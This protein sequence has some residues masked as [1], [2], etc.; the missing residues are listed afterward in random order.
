M[1]GSEDFRCGISFLSQEQHTGGTLRQEQAVLSPDSELGVMFRYIRQWWGA[2][3]SCLPCGVSVIRAPWLHGAGEVHRAG[4]HAASPCG[5][6][7]VIPSGW[8]QCEELGSHVQG[9]RRH[10]TSSI[11]ADAGQWASRQ[12]PLLCCLRAAGDAARGPS[13]GWVGPARPRAEPLAAALPL[14]RLC[15][16]FCWFW[17]ICFFPLFRELSFPFIP[18][19]TDL[20][21]GVFFRGAQITCGLFI[22]PHS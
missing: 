8:V 7:S 15:Q 6:S 20:N 3:L 10:L 22:H 18:E 16:S 19:E 9:W 13:A 12:Q 14:L 2:Q 4:A 17:R 5:V 1:H 11:P 21:V